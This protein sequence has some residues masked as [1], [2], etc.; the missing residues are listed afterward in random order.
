VAPAF[1]GLL[2]GLSLIVAIGAQNS[3]VLRQGLAGR[4]VGLIVTI[5]ATSDLLL[6][7]AGVAGVG[8]LIRSHPDGITVVRWVGAAY[9]LTY[10]G[11]SLR[12]AARPSSLPVDGRS[13]RGRRTAVLTTLAL[14]YLNPHVYLDTVVMLGS[15]ANGYGNYRWEFA[16]GA[17]LGSVLWFSGLGFGARVAS[18][19]LNRPRTWRA[20]DV[21]IGCVMIAL[22]I[23]VARI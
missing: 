8:T 5:C 21:V 10:G 4:H 16:A 15:V 7:A 23:R 2:T 22:A 11:L 13:A 14:T 9:L 3:Y 12:S 6:I 19:A 17:A 1:A 20:L 18:P